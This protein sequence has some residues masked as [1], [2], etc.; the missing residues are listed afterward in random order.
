MTTETIPVD[1]MAKAREALAAKRAAGPAP[2]V[3]PTRASRAAR[4]SALEQWLDKNEDTVSKTV[5]RYV[6]D[7]GEGV[8]ITRTGQS[9]KV[10]YFP[11]TWG[12]ESREV[13][14]HNVRSCVNEGGAR[15]DCGDCGGDCSP[16][17]MN[18]QYNN[19]PGR[20]KFATMQC[21]DC[22]RLAYDFE[23]RSVN[24]DLLRS[25]NELRAMESEGTLL[26]DPTMEELSPTLRLSTLN[27]QHMRRYHPD[28]AEARGLGREG[29]SA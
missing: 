21:P 12:W 4:P 6:G 26:K 5:E 3:T 7:G 18:P 15:Y 14:S 24:S 27:A 28:T 1:R 22:G 8:M 19:C 20:P 25:S 10:L 11:T 9:L 13:P 29:H 17:P 16:D 2:M 23:S